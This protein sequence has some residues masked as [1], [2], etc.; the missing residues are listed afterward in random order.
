MAKL[1]SPDIMKIKN[2]Q[3]VLKIIYREK[4]IYRAKI[5]DMTNMS[6]QTVTN[7]TKELLAEGLISEVTLAKKALGRNPMALS[8]NNQGIY[9]IGIEL[10]VEEVRGVLTDFSG[11]V[12]KSINEP[13]NQDKYVMDVLKNCIAFLLEGYEDNRLVKGIGIT[14]EGVV[15]DVEGIVIK[16]SELKLFEVNF[17]DELAYLGIPIIIQNDVNATAEI[18]KYKR[19][20]TKNFMVVKLGGGIGASFMI[21]RRLIR[22]TNNASGEFG[23]IKIHKDR[24]LR[25]CK[26]GG[27]G[28]LTTEASIVALE[29]KLQMSYSDIKKEVAN[30]HTTIIK[31][32]EKIAVYIGRSLANVITLLDL[33]M[34]I[35]TGPL[36]LDLRE[37]ILKGIHEEIQKNIPKWVSYK[38]LHVIGLPDMVKVGS[39]LAIE[40]FFR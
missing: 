13:L 29:E 2:K 3:K 38:Q 17:K 24:E 11:Q 26:C 20:K 18:E 19:S 12:I 4:N 23:H 36:V 34:I 28:C 15:N 16:A 37:I 39:Q 6:N 31:H 32:L 7:I 21:N 5:A 10:A 27:Y 40:K 9:V 22:S 35:L 1:T 33:D 25:K 14:V 30:G 8:I